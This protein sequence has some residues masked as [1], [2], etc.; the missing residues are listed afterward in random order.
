[1]HKPLNIAQFNDVFPD[2]NACLDHLMRTR[3]GQRF[4]CP[5]CKRDA[6]FYRVSTRRC[7]VC[8]WCG[9][10]VYPTA[11]TPFE[12]TRTP[13]KDWYYVMFLF[14]AARNGVSSKEVQRQIGVTYKTAWR[15]THEIRKYMGAVDGDAPLGGPGPG[16]I[17]EADKTYIGGKD[18]RG[19]D[20]K[21]IVLGMVERK[22]DVITRVV[23]DKRMETVMGHVQEHVAPG[24]RL[25]TDEGVAFSN[26][27]A[28][29]YRHGTVNHAAKEWVRGQVHTNTIESFWANLKR[30]I[31][32]T[33]VWV[34]EKHLQTYLWE[35]E[36]R[37]NLRKQPHL[38]FELLILSFPRPEV[39]HAPSR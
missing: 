15:M 28:L 10:Q 32:G 9:H 11:G 31:K 34:S 5:G 24:A 26:A 39:A 13:L 19:E 12:K 16:G 27:R 21:H 36:F 23:P 30:G 25:A 20:D 3:Y 8:E 29:G 4:H 17:V 22:G 38:M 7:Y 37:H 18:K 14:C 1:M 35:F 33:Y 2:D 6:H